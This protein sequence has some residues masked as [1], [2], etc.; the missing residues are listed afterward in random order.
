[1][2]NPVVTS[3]GK[4][5][6][7]VDNKF[8][9]G[10][11]KEVTEGLSRTTRPGIGHLEHCG[12]WQDT[13]GN[14][15]HSVIHF[16]IQQKRQTRGLEGYESSPLAPPTPQISF[17]M[18]YGKQEVQF[19]I[20]LGR[21]WSKFPDDMSQRDIFQRHYCHHQRMKSHQAVQ[22]PGGEGNQDK[23]ESSHYPSYRRSAEPDRDYSDSFR[24]KR[25]RA[26]QHSSGVRPFRHQKI[27]GKESPFFTIPGSFQEKTRIQGKNKTSFIQRQ[28]ESDP[29]IQ[30]LLSLGKEVHNSHK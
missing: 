14:H 10:T 30:K 26:T 27:S 21:T 5:P 3:K 23:G 8:V 29:M 4:F 15:T 20:T 9:K 16:P 1:M 18:E 6:K 11:V 28:K 25:S 12:E 2:I 22:T 13:E 17:A 24:L 19:S 7:A